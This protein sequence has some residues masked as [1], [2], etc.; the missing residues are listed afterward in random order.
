M[1]SVRVC[2]TDAED[3]DSSGESL[4]QALTSADFRIV[5]DQNYDAVP[6]AIDELSNPALI[7]S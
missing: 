5:D 7:I 3:K 4:G 6:L 1:T 2:G